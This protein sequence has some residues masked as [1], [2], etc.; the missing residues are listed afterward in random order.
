MFRGAVFIDALTVFNEAR[1]KMS[2]ILD[3]SVGLCYK[4]IPV[5]IK[6]GRNVVKSH[7]EWFSGPTLRQL[8]LQDQLRTNFDEEAFKNLSE[9]PLKIQLID[10]TKHRG[11]G[12]NTTVPYGRVIS[13][14]LK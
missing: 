13:R 10:V 6:Y 5:N 9:Q 7:Y 3:R 11:V 12:G 2:K 8:V 1:T 14:C 4:I